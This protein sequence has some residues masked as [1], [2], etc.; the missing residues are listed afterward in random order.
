MIEGLER[1]AIVNQDGMYMYGEDGRKVLVTQLQFEDGRMIA[2]SKWG[3]EES[4]EKLKLTKEE[5]KIQERIKVCLLLYM[6]VTMYVTK[7]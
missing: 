3:Q 4:T 1:P 2:A 5:E 6:Y 7:M